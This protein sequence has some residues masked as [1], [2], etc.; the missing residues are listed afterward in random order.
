MVRDGYHLV[1]VDGDSVVVQAVVD[2]QILFGGRGV[3]VGELRSSSRTIVPGNREGR[4]SSK[5]QGRI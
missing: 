5:R 1:S 3:G 4:I 2:L